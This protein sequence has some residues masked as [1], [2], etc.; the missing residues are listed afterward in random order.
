MAGDKEFEQRLARFRKLP[1]FLRVVVS[2]PRT[3]VA[4]AYKTAIPDRLTPSPSLR[5]SC[6]RTRCGWRRAR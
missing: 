1:M 2:R 3:V 4:L 5:F 6:C